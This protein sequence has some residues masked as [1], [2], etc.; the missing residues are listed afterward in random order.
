MLELRELVGLGMETIGMWS[1]SYWDVSH[2]AV[3]DGSTLPWP[4]FSV[5]TS[6]NAIECQSNSLLSNMVTSLQHNLAHVNKCCV[7][8]SVRDSAGLIRWN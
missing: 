7:K 8:D 1:G 2:S 6:S 5:W 3:D 4:T